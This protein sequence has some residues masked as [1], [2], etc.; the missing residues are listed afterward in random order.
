M[1]RKPAVPQPPARK[2]RGNEIVDEEPLPENG[3]DVFTSPSGA[4]YEGD[5]KRFETGVKRHGKGEF[6]NPDFTY[7]GDFEED[8]FHG[9]GE[10]QY[11]SGLVYVGEFAHGQIHGE[12]EIAFLDRSR[13]KGQWRNGRMHGIGTYYTI[14]G[15]Q[16]T[17][18]WCHG[19]STCPIFPQMLPPSNEE[20]EEEEMDME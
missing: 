5:W 17:G 6:T 12:G 20:E 7:V 18:Q 4:R 10:I 15:R 16:W 11:T 8:L 2:G 3:H 1:N 14:D 13:Y 9:A 19:Q